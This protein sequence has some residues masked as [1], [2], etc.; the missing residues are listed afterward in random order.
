MPAPA[1]S[2]PRF[3][4]QVAFGP[5]GAAGQ[6]RLQR[7]RVAVVGV[8]A[9]GG[10]AA[11][12][13]CR[14]GVGSLRL[15]DRDLVEESNLPRQ[16]LFEQRHALERTPKAEAACETLGRVG[17]PTQLEA[18]CV[19]LAAGE[20]SAC[21]EDVDLV[22]DGTDNVATRYLL[23]DWCVRQ[24]RAW[25]Y[26]GVVGSEARALLVAPQQSACLRCLFPEPPPAGQLATCDSSGVLG[27]AVLVAAGW[28]VA[29]ALRYLAREESGSAPGAGQLFAADVWL[30][31]ARVHQTSRDPECPCCGQGHYE[32]LERSEH[33]RPLGLCG[34]NAVQV[35]GSG[36]APD[37]DR[38]S[39]RLSAGGALQLKRA[40]SLLRFEQE[41]LRFTVFPD[42]RCLVEGTEDLA[43]AEALCGRL[44]T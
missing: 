42:G 38:L 15:I 35:P 3:A 14:A 27:A 23:N 20:L 43:R 7:A 11:L 37:F 44:L 1:E 25:I 30:P 6:E 40:G 2:T 41:G 5:L 18:R 17:G 39:R 34:R 32:Y 8:G 4:R 12:G 36:R 28:Q 13:L 19:H 21:L 10:A 31:S 22:V 26:G 9:L 29:L 24:K 16:V 33:Q